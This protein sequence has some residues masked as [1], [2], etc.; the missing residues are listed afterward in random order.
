MEGCGREYGVGGDSSGG[1]WEEVL[2]VE[3]AYCKYN[4]TCTGKGYTFAVLNENN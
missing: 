1:V 3:C 2:V 4:V